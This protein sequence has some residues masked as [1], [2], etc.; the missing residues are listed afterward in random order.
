MKH[1]HGVIFFALSTFAVG[2]MMASVG[3]AQESI[4]LRYSNW[5]GTSHDLSIVADQWCKEVEKRTNGK[6]KVRYYP[7]GSLVTAPQTYDSIIKGVIDV[8]NVCTSYNKGKFP[9]SEAGDLPLGH[10]SGSIATRMFNEYYKKFNPKDMSDVKPMHFHGQSPPITHTKK[11]VNKLEDLK[12]MRIRLGVDPSIATNLGAVPVVMPMGDAYDAI[13]KGVVDGVFCNYEALKGWKLGEVVKYTTESYGMSFGS[14]F[15]VAMNKKKWDSIPP[16]A[17]K[18]IEQINVEWIEKT[19][20]CW[21][22]ITRE[23]KEFV[24]QRGNKVIELSPEE[25]A[26][27]AE[28]MQPVINDYIK[29][30]KEKN[31]PGEEVVKFFRDYLKEHQK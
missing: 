31:L 6:V 1:R 3:H 17:Q 23:G 25:N 12:G 16:D 5:F 21:D 29:R 9:L 22:R 26:R 10:K 8:G 28:K 19:A 18:I 7:G 14:L 30:A 2:I 27:W 20:E 11:L 4:T 24:I 13:A 15:V